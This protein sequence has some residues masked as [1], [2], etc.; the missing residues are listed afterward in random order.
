MYSMVKGII[1]TNKVG[2]KNKRRTIVK[3]IS[4]ASLTLE[5]AMISQIIN[6]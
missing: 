3:G 6:V 4:P 1:K 5:T 2:K